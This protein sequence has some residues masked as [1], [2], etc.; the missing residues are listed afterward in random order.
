MTNFGLQATKV[1]VGKR[2]IQSA[3]LSG[4]IP[5]KHTFL[6]AGAALKAT[7]L[8]GEHLKESLAPTIF[9]S[10]LEFSL[11]F[12]AFLDFLDFSLCLL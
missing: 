9:P 8:L 2:D 7:Q 6:P 12:N 1:E 11:C 3:L 4:G 10:G 5:L